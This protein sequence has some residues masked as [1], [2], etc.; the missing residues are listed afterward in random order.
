MD[1]NVSPSWAWVLPSLGNALTYVVPPVLIAVVIGLLCALPTLAVAT[2]DRPHWA[3]IAS[4]AVIFSIFAA[5]IAI[6]LGATGQP[7]VTAAFGAVVTISTTYL[8]VAIGKD[9]DNTAITVAPGLVAFY[10]TLP[11]VVL[12]WE[13]F[14]KGAGA[15]GH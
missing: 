7:L 8:S 14:Q 9:Q 2:T 12:Y 13:W 15:A 6:F 11:L 4:V 1:D 5:C 3:R 10:L